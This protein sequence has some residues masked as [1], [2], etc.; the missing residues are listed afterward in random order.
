MNGVGISSLGNILETGTDTQ[1]AL[2]AFALGS[3]ANSDDARVAITDSLPDLV[4]FARTGTQIQREHAAFALGWLSRNDTICDMV[5]TYGG[6]TPLVNLVQ[7]G[8]EDQKNQAAL[9]LG[10]LAVDST[11]NTATI[12]ASEKVFSALVELVQTGTDDQNSECS[13]SSV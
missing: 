10:N 5:I 8:T 9:A 2:A 13:A 11:E 4:A 12:F 7:P 1:K 6:I 3:L